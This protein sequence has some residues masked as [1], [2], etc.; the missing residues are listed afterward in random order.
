MDESNDLARRIFL[1][2]PWLT[3]LLQ[4]R[5][6]WLHIG[7]RSRPA[8]GPY[9]PPFHPTC[10]SRHIEFRHEGAPQGRRNVLQE[11]DVS[12]TVPSVAVLPFDDL[13]AHQNLGYLGDGVAEDI[14]TALSR[15]PD[16]V[17]VARGSHFASQDTAIEIG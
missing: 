8:Y 10:R 4:H 5:R 3:L 12:S 9:R 15:F 13:S 7:Q 1:R 14:I 2:S 11:Q 16:L 6:G 17:V